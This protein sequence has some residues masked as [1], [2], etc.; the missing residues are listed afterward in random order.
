MNYWIL[1]AAFVSG[2]TFVAHIFGGGPDILVP[3][4]AGEMSQYLKT[5]WTVVW[6]AVSVTIFIGTVCLIVEAIKPG[7]FTGLIWGI[8][9][10]YLAFTV[11]FIYYGIAELGSLW[12]M[13][14]WIAFSL[15]VVL[16]AIGM[17]RAGQTAPK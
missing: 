15:I 14:Q 4:Q 7:K 6:H 10:Q 16:A 1:G 11:L 2:L 17:R 5:I 3:M 13:P 12:P 9:A 8:C